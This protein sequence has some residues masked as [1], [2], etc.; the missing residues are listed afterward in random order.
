MS[1]VEVD[2]EPPTSP[3]NTTVA[4]VTAGSY[5][6]RRVGPSQMLGLAV[7]LQQMNLEELDKKSM[8]PPTVRCTRAAEVLVVSGR[9]LREAINTNDEA[10]QDLRR[11]LWCMYAKEVGMRVLRAREPFRE[12]PESSLAQHIERGW[13]LEWDD[14]HNDIEVLMEH[15]LGIL[16]TGTCLTLERGGEAGRRSDKSDSSDLFDASEW[17]KA[18]ALLRPEERVAIQQDD[19][20]LSAAEKNMAM[21]AGQLHPSL[22]GQMPEV[23][24]AEVNAARQPSLEQRLEGHKRIRILC[25][26]VADSMRLHMEAPHVYTIS[27][28]PNTRRFVPPRTSMARLSRA[29]D[30]RR[31]V[32][33]AST[34]K[35]LGSPA[36]AA[37]VEG[38][39][40]RLFD[41]IRGNKGQASGA[42]VSGRL[43]IRTM[44]NGLVTIGDA[45]PAGKQLAAVEEV[46][47]DVASAS[48]D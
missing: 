21:A 23:N 45:P 40:K 15:H 41:M 36:G 18:G 47:I 39:S 1:A 29:A 11:E 14:D 32:D 33:K 7:V 48:A 34:K 12:W 24:V 2:Y 30:L 46:D 27:S 13:L 44:A 35:L 42:T 10:G 17:S 28:D 43:N 25:L 8:L 6:G 16:I 20:M 22:M 5:I 19:P 9:S 37:K 38:S 31:S 26:P 4:E 3:G